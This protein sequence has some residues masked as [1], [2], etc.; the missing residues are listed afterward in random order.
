MHIPLLT[1]KHRSNIPSHIGLHQHLYFMFASALLLLMMMSWLRIM[2]LLFNHE[3]IGDTRWITLCEAL[4]NGVRFDLR[5][6]VYICV[7]L[8]LGLLYRP[9]IRRRF[10]QRLWLTACA[11]LVILLG[12][13][14][15]NFYREFHQRL[16]VLVFQYLNEDPKTVLSMLWHGFP[17]IK[18]LLA[19]S[20]LSG[21]FWFGLSIIDRH[22]RNTSRIASNKTQPAGV[23]LS[24]GI[25]FTLCLVLAVLAARGTLRQGPPLRWGDAFTTD[26]VFANHLGLNGTLTLYTAAK[27]RYSDHSNNIWKA[28]MPDEQAIAVTRNLL[29]TTHDQPADTDTAAVRRDLTPPQ[30]GQLPVRNVVVILM[31]SFA[32]HF[33]GALGS[34]A[35][36]TPY[37]DQLS[38]EG[39]LFERFFANGTHTHQGMFA[40]MACF[41]NLP[42]F[43]YLMQTPE[44]GNHFSGLPQLLSARNYDDLYVYNGDFA[45]DNQ[46]GF[47]SNQGMTRFIGRNDYKN[48][49]VSDPTWGVSDQDMF[50]RAAE[51]LLRQAPDKP[52]YALLQ[53]LSNHTPYALPSSLPVEPVT[54]YG[55]L[56][57]HLTAMRYADW[58]LG[59]FF[60]KAKQAPY[61]KDTLFVLVGDHG[62]GAHEQLTDMDLYRF[63][64]PLLL[65]APGVQETFGA[66]RNTVGSQV[67]VVPTIMGRLNG[68]T[69]HQCWG[70]DLLSLPETDPGF[71][72]IKPSG[73]DQTVAMLQ[74]EQL[75]VQPKGMPQRLF[76]YQLGTQPQ[77]ALLLD[78]AVGARMSTQLSAY[79]QAATSSLLSNTTGAEAPS[80][81]PMGS[82][83][84]D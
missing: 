61:Y 21:L 9:I 75:L 12:I 4:L 34:N 67:D 72:I 23:L 79:I 68:Q 22:T 57:E 50:D 11:S 45:W 62:F 43:E 6:T 53:T 54:G 44:G 18:L 49:V 66:V 47:F 37:F 42:G 38:K 51:E 76:T 35:E 36:I 70:R 19:W 82:A 10:W 74:G 20:V 31:E 39:L 77:A 71:A 7:P 81:E 46:R 2:L 65:I 52:F 27:S 16:N 3:L 26:S 73:S 78:A 40:T 64:V 56:N 80:N 32:G 33:V 63:H 14:E 15:L 13:I 69:R 28:G 59:Q 5:L 41:P 1:A 24:H 25:V 48:P 8:L 60:E 84:A 55:S 17:V 29:H 83:T 30:N 58:A